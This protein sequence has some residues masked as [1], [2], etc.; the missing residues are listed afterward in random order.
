M[1]IRRTLAFLIFFQA[2]LLV[3]FAA[4]QEAESGVAESPE[5]I[6]QREEWYHQ[7]RAY[8][9]KHIPA[10]VRARA[11]QETGHGS[12]GGGD[13]PTRL[14]CLDADRSGANHSSAG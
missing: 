8:P 9:L 4:A 13:A 11:S 14:I 3:G 7:L 12:F 2:A 6:R 10:G 5:M 1:T